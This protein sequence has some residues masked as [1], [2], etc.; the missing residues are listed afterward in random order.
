MSKLIVFLRN[1][2]NEVGESS[3][4]E[5]FQMTIDD[6]EFN[7]T[8]FNKTTNSNEFMIICSRCKSVFIRY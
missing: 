6:I 4:K 1:L 3:F 7:R 2:F 5:I 8:G